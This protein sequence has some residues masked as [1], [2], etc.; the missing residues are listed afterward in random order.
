MEKSYTAPGAIARL[1]GEKWADFN[2]RQQAHRAA[3]TPKPKRRRIARKKVS[4]ETFE[5][6]MDNLGESPDY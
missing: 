1:P 6:R 2:A 3:N 4:E 5:T